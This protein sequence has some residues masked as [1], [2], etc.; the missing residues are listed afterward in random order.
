M[1]Q[2]QQQLFP[3]RHVTLNH[4]DDDGMGGLINYSCCCD[5]Q[6]PIIIIIIRTHGTAVHGKFLGGKQWKEEMML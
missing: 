4:G 6:H 3:H 1:W 5:K 2:Q